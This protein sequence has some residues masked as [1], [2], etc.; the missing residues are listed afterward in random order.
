MSPRWS[1]DGRWIAFMGR[2]PGGPVR[3]YR[4]AA[5]GGSPEE[6]WAA[7]ERNLLAPT[8]SPDGK[9]LI[10]GQEGD[11]ARGEQDFLCRLELTSRKLSKISGSEGSVYAVWSPDGR[12]LAAGS[13]GT[14]PGIRILDLATQQWFALTR[15]GSNDFAWSHDSDYLYIDSGEAGIF[16]IELANRREEKV[17]DTRGIKRAAGNFG[18]WL[19]LAPD[20]SPLI[21]RSLNSDRVYALE[22]EAP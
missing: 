9:F 4:V 7:A 15:R 5:D 14:T 12:Y 3:I 2:T 13:P 18:I 6:I 10:F 21:L 1:P 16:R 11:A 20:D 19:G 22:W 17:A 8:W